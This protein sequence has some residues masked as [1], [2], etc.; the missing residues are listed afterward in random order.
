MSEVGDHELPPLRP[1]VLRNQGP[2]CDPK[3]LPWAGTILFGMFF[4]IGVVLLSNGIKPWI[5][6]NLIKLIIA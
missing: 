2:F 1:Y 6:K 3:K 4:C 5:R